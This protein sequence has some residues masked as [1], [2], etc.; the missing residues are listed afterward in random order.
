[1]TATGSWRTSRAPARRRWPAKSTRNP[2]VQQYLPDGSY[3][4][5]LDG[6]EVRII[7]AGIT[8]T[9]ADGSPVQ[10]S[11]RLITTLTDHRRYPADALARLYHERHLRAVSPTYSRKR[12]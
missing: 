3:L 8:M 5:H 4:S 10:D 12:V 7:E 2:R 11:Y 1:M 6:L 9:G